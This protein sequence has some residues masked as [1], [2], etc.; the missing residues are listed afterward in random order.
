LCDNGPSTCEPKKK[1]RNK[2]L[3]VATVVP[4]AVATLL[5]VAGFL[6]LHRMRN[7]QGDISS[8]NLLKKYFIEEI[9]SCVLIEY[10][11]IIHDSIQ[12]HGW[13][14]TQGLLALKPVHTYLRTESSPT[15]S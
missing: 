12:I 10:F 8:R 15:R 6:I 2:T 7:R 5:F 3:I 13:Q 11:H 14:T 4:I 1:K 9:I